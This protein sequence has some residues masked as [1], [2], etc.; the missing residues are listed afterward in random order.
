MPP[1]V[2]EPYVHVSAPPCICVGRRRGR[3]RARERTDSSVKNLV[4]LMRTYPVDVIHAQ[5]SYDYAWSSIDAS[6]D[7]L[8][9]VRDHAAA[10]VEHSPK[11]FWLARRMMSGYRASQ[12]E[13]PERQLRVLVPAPYARSA[14]QGPGHS[15]LL[16]ETRGR[17][18]LRDSGADSGVDGPVITTVANGFGPWKNVARA[19][20]AFSLYAAKCQM[21]NFAWLERIW[22]NPGGRALTLCRL[23]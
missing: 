23:A 14:V 1:P 8:V 18:L 11:A 21:P 6:P 9:T 15:Q 19:I 13:Q 5:W 16:P 2:M 3:H 17:H 20:R 7:A 22:A 4:E 10:I 12:G